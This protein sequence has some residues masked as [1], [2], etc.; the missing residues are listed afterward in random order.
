M[1]GKGENAGNQHFLFSP[2]YFQ[3]FSLR[4]VVVKSRNHSAKGFSLYPVKM[5]INSFISFSSNV[6]QFLS[7]VVVKGKNNF[8]KSFSTYPVTAWNIQSS[9]N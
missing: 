5:Q 2:Q 8:A 1:V 4:V 3:V 9:R 6:F 7:L